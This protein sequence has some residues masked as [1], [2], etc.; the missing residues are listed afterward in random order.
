MRAVHTSIV[1]SKRRF[2]I[3]LGSLHSFRHA[4]LVHLL[5]EPVDVVAAFYIRERACSSLLRC[6]QSYYITKDFCIMFSGGLTNF[7]RI[8]ENTRLP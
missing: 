2:N 6:E 7:P 1:M 8:R 3:E 4:G 5:P